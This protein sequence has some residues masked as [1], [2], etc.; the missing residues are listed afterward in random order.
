MIWLDK[1]P[2][3]MKSN[4]LF[5]GLLSYFEMGLLPNERADT[6]IGV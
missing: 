4:A 6:M 5:F 3:S 1:P 2:W